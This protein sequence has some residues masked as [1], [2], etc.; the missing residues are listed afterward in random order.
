MSNCGNAS[1]IG[2]RAGKAP[3]PAAARFRRQTQPGLS[4]G[5]WPC[6]FTRLPSCLALAVAVMAPATVNASAQEADADADS[7]S[8]RS[9]AFVS[10]RDGDYEIYVM[11]ADGSRIMPL[12]IDSG[13]ELSP[14]WIDTA[15]E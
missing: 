12:T 6:K 5:G 3:A 4:S 11:N 2:G 7:G 14:K 1:V 8:S 13:R 15:A 9:I 10:T